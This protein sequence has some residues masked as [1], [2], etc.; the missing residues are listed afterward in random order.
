MLGWFRSNSFSKYGVANFLRGIAHGVLGMVDRDDR[1]RTSIRMRRWVARQPNQWPKEVKS[2]V[3]VG[4]NTRQEPIFYDWL[5]LTVLWIEPIPEA[6]A[7]LTR[8]I[9]CFPRQSAVEALITDKIG[10]PYQFNVS[11]GTGVIDLRP[12]RP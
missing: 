9:S 5:G 10:Q 7:E 8:N 2:L 3:H 12:C 6:F 11:G 1:V 4:A